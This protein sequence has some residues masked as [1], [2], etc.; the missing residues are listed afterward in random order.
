MPQSLEHAT[1]DLRVM[2]SSPTLGAEP[3]HTNK[4]RRARMGCDKQNIYCETFCEGEGA[5]ESE[6]RFHVATQT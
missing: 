6:E 3:T 5:R 4:K 1:L 2:S